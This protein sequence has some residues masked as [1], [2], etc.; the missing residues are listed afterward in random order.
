G[1]LQNGG[2]TLRLVRPISTNLDEIIDEVHYDDQ[3]PWPPAADG[4]GP[5]LQLID[6]TQENYRA[7][8]WAALGYTPG[9][10]NSVRLALPP[11]PPV[12]IN[13]VLPINTNSITDNFGQREPWIE[14]FNNGTGVVSLAG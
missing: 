1:N 11:F 12:W 14:L 5:S 7:C 4:T 10:T 8:N 6:P 3:A 2:E 13:E 9:A